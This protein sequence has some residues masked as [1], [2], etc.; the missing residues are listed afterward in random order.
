MHYKTFLKFHLLLQHVWKL[1]NLDEKIALPWRHKQSNT[2]ADRKNKLRKLYGS[3][4]KSV[5]WEIY[6]IYHLD[7]ELFGYDFRKEVLEI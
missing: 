4:S 5:L 3:V 7:Y 6:G 2:L 1:T